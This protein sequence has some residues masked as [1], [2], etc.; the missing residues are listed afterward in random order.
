[1]TTDTESA[2][3]SDNAAVAPDGTPPENVFDFLQERGRRSA[4]RPAS[5]HKGGL[6][7]R[8]SQPQLTSGRRLQLEFAVQCALVRVE[9]RWWH[10]LSA[11]EQEAWERL[12]TVLRPEP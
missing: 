9:T 10:E 11:S 1:M 6:D 8:R 12:A 2:G 7:W 5:A 4:T 3:D